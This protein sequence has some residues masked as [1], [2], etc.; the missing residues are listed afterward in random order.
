MSG[1]NGEYVTADEFTRMV[2]GNLSR[3]GTDYID[4]MYLTG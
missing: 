4:I 1:Q 3:L 2:D